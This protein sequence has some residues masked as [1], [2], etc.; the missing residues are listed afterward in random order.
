VPAI[1]FPLVD[2]K[3]RC[4]LTIPLSFD[5]GM[6]EDSRQFMTSKSQAATLVH[7]PRWHGGLGDLRELADHGVPYY[8]EVVT[9]PSSAVCFLSRRCH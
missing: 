7:V 4:S 9:V 6:G 1:R 8:R 2:P 3:G 5:C